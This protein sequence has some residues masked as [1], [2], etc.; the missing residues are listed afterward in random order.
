GGAWPPS[1]RAA[2][3][4]SGRRVRAEAAGRAKPARPA[5]VRRV[6]PRRAG[7]QSAPPGWRSRGTRSAAS[8]P[9]ARPAPS[10]GPRS[11]ASVFLP[12][13]HLA[14]HVVV[15][16]HGGHLLFDASHA[17]GGGD[18]ESVAGG[19]EE[20]RGVAVDLGI[21]LGPEPD[22]VGLQDADEILR[23]HSKKGKHF[24]QL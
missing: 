22:A 17:A 24:A 6:S 16:D 23:R 20:R 1:T 2:R 4:R 10:R 21:D 9:A 13:E 15:P 7:A 14:Q 12:V 19:A 18:A 3:P 5:A 11:G 8:P